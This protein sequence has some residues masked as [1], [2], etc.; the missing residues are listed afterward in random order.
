MSSGRSL[1]LPMSVQKHLLTAPVDVCKHSC[2]TGTCGI[3][4]CTKWDISHCEVKHLNYKGLLIFIV[5]LGYTW[6]S[7]I[8]WVFRLCEKYIHMAHS[9]WTGLQTGVVRIFV[10]RSQNISQ[11]SCLDWKVL[12]FM[13]Q[14]FVTISQGTLRYR[15]NTFAHRCNVQRCFFSQKS[16]LIH[17]TSSICVFNIYL[18][19]DIESID[20]SDFYIPGKFIAANF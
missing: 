16:T 17:I 18:G 3:W 7:F 6:L 20:Q 5:K 9:N 12:Y 13:W 1:L 15:K 14:I 10:V 19:L 4:N 2:G 11:F 8:T